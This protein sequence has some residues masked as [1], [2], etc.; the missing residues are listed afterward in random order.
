MYNCF[1]VTI[2]YP[3]LKKEKYV[4]KQHTIFYRSSR[5]LF[6]IR[7]VIIETFNLLWFVTVTRNNRINICTNKKIKGLFNFS[8]HSQVSLRKR[9]KLH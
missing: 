6:L 2:F 5:R 4:L 7:G 9:D 8:N 1:K 3:P